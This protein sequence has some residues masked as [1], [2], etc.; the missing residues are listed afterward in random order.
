ML[1]A[2]GA[3]VGDYEIVAPI[4][5]GGMGE[6][7]R[8]KDTRLRRDVALKVL[9]AAFARDPDRMARFQREAEVLASL[10]HPN[11][12]A[13]HG[14]V[15]QDAV[16]ALVMELVEG[17]TLAD[18]L[19][20]AALPVEEA[21]H[22]AGQ[23]AEALE[24]AHEKGIVHRDLKP[25]NVKVTPE[26]KVKVL[27]FGLAKQAAGTTASGDPSISPTLTVAATQAGVIMG[28]TPYMAPEQ[29]RGHPVDRRADIWSFGVVLYEM[30]S[31]KRAFAGETTS[32]IL[33]GVL[34]LDPDWTALPAAT[35]PSVAALLR[36]CLTKDRKQRLQ[37]I[38]EARI[39]IANA[40]AHPEEGPAGAVAAGPPAARA[41]WRRVLPWGLAGLALAAAVY[42][43][44]A[45][46]PAPSPRVR[47]FTITL[48]PGPPNS[49]AGIPDLALSPNGNRLVYAGTQGGKTQLYLRP[50]DQFDAQPL[51]GTEGASG[52]FFSPDGQ[53]L[54][55]FADDR[56]KKVALAGGPVQPLCSVPATW[57]GNAA[58]WSPA[59]T[60]YFLDGRGLGRVAAGGGDCAQLTRSDGS[61]GEQ[62][63]DWPESLPGGESLLFGVIKG[64]NA[65]NAHIA[66]LSLKTG[67]WRT[68]PQTGTNPRYVGQRYLVYAQD[69]ALL[70]APFDAAHLEVT[71]S[72]TRVVDGVMTDAY[73]GSAH[74]AL[75]PDGTLAYVAG[76]QAQAMRELA[77]VDQNGSSEVLTRSPGAYEDLA[78]SPD[79][80]HVALTIQGATWA[81]WIYDIVRRTL[82]RLTFDH[83]DGDPCWTPDGK[84]VVYGS[85]QTGVFKLYWKPADGSGA[86][87]ELQSSKNWLV[88]TSFAPDQKEL[89]YMEITGENRN[90][91]WILPLTG[92]RRPRPFLTASYSTGMP[93][94]S[95]DGRWLAY[96]SDESGR[97]EIYVQ[98]YPGPGGKWPISND[99]GEKPVWSRDGRQL[100]YRNGNKLMAVAIQTK[101]AFSAG[102]PRLLFQGAYF[103][104]Y[105]DYDV[106]PDGKHFVFI[107]EA[108]QPHGAR[109]INVVLNWLEELKQKVS[110]EKR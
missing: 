30:L 73:F 53:W 105:H 77:L 82:T 90:R 1:L 20:T 81:I 40:L 99:G 25:A 79:G 16:R 97:S 78:V 109:Q 12:A 41:A 2:A 85:T 103:V 108:E 10:N 58:D 100:F 24:A 56:L 51:A 65:E 43:R 29:A 22:A 33:A 68:L 63:H 110:S 60:I 52:P 26:G 27:D 62:Y 59:G 87:E 9:P 42:F 89:A 95:P 50:L 74:F 37:A 5:A 94:F 93:D 72:P 17:P 48:P 71:A 54:G 70:A 45:R 49:P 96:Q 98:Q 83:N 86:E 13:I 31:G 35:P 55:F 47:R 8:A 6:V 38:G 69:G 21:L 84:R 44:V 66:I 91:I 34:K 11:I 46:P 39:A 88:A 57:L 104:S 92:D 15:E 101:P 28:T 23:I 19:A 7:Y 61:Q 36:R 67:K 32:D 3:R 80:R 64:F 18:R 75:S 106:M 102:T 4:G 107:R 76:G 14:L